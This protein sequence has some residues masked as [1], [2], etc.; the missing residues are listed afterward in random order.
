MQTLF[1]LAFVPLVPIVTLWVIARYG[2]IRTRWWRREH[3]IG[4]ALFVGTIAFLGGFVGPLILA[5]DANQGPLL[6]IFFTGPIG[7][8]V[9]AAW[10]LVRAAKRGG[11]HP[12][13]SS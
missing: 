10:G 13:P 7:L 9:G 2:P 6:G 11:A 8:L 4:F 12:P 1:F 5:P 3:P